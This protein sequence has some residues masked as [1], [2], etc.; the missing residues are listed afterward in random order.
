[1]KTVTNRQ[2]WREGIIRSGTCVK[3]LGES[4]THRR[5]AEVDH[6]LFL[7]FLVMMMRSSG[8]A[9]R[10]ALWKLSSLLM[11]SRSPWTSA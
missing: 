1:M 7:P 3:M 4:N 9:E 6:V 2:G 5:K 11:G 8:L 10:T